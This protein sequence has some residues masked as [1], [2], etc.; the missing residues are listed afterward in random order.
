MDF[1]AFES[2]L[3]VDDADGHCEW[4]SWRY[5]DGNEVDC[6]E[7]NVTSRFTTIVLQINKTI[8]NITELGN[9]R[10]TCRIISQL[11]PCLTEI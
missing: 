8:L 5:G 1:L 10:H 11:R 7:K 6:V 4:K 2:Q 3:S 9:L